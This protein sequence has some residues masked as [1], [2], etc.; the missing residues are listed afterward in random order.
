MSRQISESANQRIGEST[1]LQPGGFADLQTRTLADLHLSQHSLQDFVDCNR[2]FQLR[3]LKQ[4]AWP[5]VKAEP[6]EKWETQQ[7]LG[8]QFHHMAHQHALGI[9]SE[10]IEAGIDDEDLRRWWHNFTAA[11][12]PNLPAGL[13][14]AETTLIASLA[15]HR[16]MARYDL[17]AAD[18]G[19]RWVIVD[20]K[21]TRPTKPERL[22]ERLQSVVYPYV[23]VEAGSTLNGGRPVAPEQVTLIYWFADA[24]DDPLT[25]PYD[26][27]RHAANRQRLTAL[28]DEIEALCRKNVE[29]WPLTPEARTCKFC[30]YRTL[31]NRSTATDDLEE[32]DEEPETDDLLTI[33]IDQIAEIAF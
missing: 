22:R 31:C 32:M 2:R 18:P 17:L 4:I 23:L 13:R 33:D 26:A 8:Q 5:T 28:I 12:P 27:A 6:V 19:E 21:I 3:Y 11:P 1:G 25:L 24:P 15:S 9:P 7:R 14:R 29:T 10:R 20:W 30:T 16:L